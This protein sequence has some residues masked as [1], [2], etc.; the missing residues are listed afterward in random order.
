MM[1]AAPSSSALLQTT[2]TRADAPD[3]QPDG[4]TDRQTFTRRRWTRPHN[5][6]FPGTKWRHLC[7]QPGNQRMLP[8]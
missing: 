8:F 5:D 6:A 7:V 3:S 2:F 1:Q 4:K